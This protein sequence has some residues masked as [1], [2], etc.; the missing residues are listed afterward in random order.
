MGSKTLAG[1]T[2]VVVEDNR[3]SREGLAVVLREEGAVVALAADGQETLAYLRS[4]PPPDL[5][6][7]DMMLPGIDGWGV[8]AERRRDPSMAAVPVLILTGL[9]IASPDWAAS[10]GA[11][12]YL[13]KPVDAEGLLA[14]IRRCCRR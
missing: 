9:G 4:R 6:L 13:R 5:V 11:A 7:L 2:V 3:I 10:L 1:L 12:G 14:E 8:L